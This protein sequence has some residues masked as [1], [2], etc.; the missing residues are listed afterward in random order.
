MGRRE[1]R[2]EPFVTPGLSELRLTANKEREEKMENEFINGTEWD[3]KKQT[4]EKNMKKII[5][6]YINIYI[7][8]LKLA[9]K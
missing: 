8:I 6:I 5:K 7:H 2:I 3:G 4:N 1:K 9:V